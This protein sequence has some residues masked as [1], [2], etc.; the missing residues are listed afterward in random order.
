MTDTEQ[1]AVCLGLLSQPPL[2]TYP[3]SPQS[4]QGFLDNLHNLDRDDHSV[5]LKIYQC[6]CCGLVQHSLPP[7]SYYKEVIRAVAFS[8]EMGQFRLSQMEQWIKEFK[9]ADKRILEIGSGKGEYLELLGKSG[10][11]KLFGIEHS[12][13]SVGVAKQKG[14]DVKQGYICKGFKNPW[15]QNFD[16]FVIFSFLEHWP[17]L[18]ESLRALR[19]TLNEGCVGLIEVPNFELIL[20]N[21]LYSEFTT[22]H[23]YYFDRRTLRTVLE[24]NGFE[25]MSIEDVWH[26]YI[27]SARVRKR[28]ILNTSVFHHKQG[29]IVQELNQFVG[30]FR[31]HEVVIWG[32]GHQALAVIAMT[33]LQ[34]SVAYVVDSANFKQGKYT[35]ATHLLIKPPSSLN[36]DGVKAVVIMAA[37]YSD[38]IA[39]TLKSSFSSIEHVAILRED[40]L[41]VL[42]NDK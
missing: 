36:E 23:I 17:N 29:K 10:A 5:E 32:A 6:S 18:N 19:D 30:G 28:D 8:P 24:L 41:E 35:P 15:E 1:C 20:E 26:D 31:P 34:D 33:K 3:G 42:N 2:L 22:D 39:R 9:L 14:L 12:L 37:A 7:V 11:K 13:E 27:L 25:V 21:G 38:E 4:A 40:S 16:A